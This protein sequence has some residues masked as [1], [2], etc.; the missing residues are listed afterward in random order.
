MKLKQIA[1]SVIA[2]LAAAP[3][4][5]TAADQAAEK[6]QIDRGRYLAI[7][8]G[9]N[10]CH[11]PHYM[12]RDGKVP[13][14]E[15]LTG[16]AM[17]FQG[18]W[19]TTYPVNLRVLAHQMNEAQ[20]LARARSQMRPPMPWFNLAKMT[21]GDLRALHRYLRS[22][23]PKG[24]PAPAYAAPGTAVKTPYISFVPVMPQQPQRVGEAKP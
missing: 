4:I 19:G 7:V 3:M 13:E 1:L 21:D 14:A 18:P 15:W 6:R 12:E 9:C 11:T 2:C 8:G 5:A 24:E 17:G 10:D 22:L 20:W 23:G 16:S